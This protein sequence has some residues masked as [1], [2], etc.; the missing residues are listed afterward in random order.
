MRRLLRFCWLLVGI[1]TVSVGRAATIPTLTGRVVD[2][3][4]V[5]TPQEK[6]ALTQT[7][8]AL[9]EKTGGQM[10]VCIES[11]L[12]EDTTL[13]EHTYNIATAW[14]IGHK[15]HDNGA[16]LYMAMNDRRFRLEIGYG[17]E[18]WINDARAG[19]ILRK[20]TP[21]LREG[22]TADAILL[23]ITHVAYFVEEKIPA[24]Q[25]P[26]KL[27]TRTKAILA[28]CVLVFIL[29]YLWSMNERQRE[30]FFFLL[31][32]YNLVD[33]ILI[34]LMRGGGRGGPS[35]FGGGGGGFSGGG[36]SFGGGGASGRW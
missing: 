2:Q 34:A 3:A 6:V 14:G 29:L 12:P 20:M 31:F 10:A 16:L 9:E 8:L 25:T 36:G 22:K 26:A 7:L 5:L 35:G 23:A 18:G 19:D 27:S 17:W 28:I 4:G 33:F 13:E 15:D 1:L 30:R 24:P 32:I 11:T 21:L